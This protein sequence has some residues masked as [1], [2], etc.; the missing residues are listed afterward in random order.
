[1]CLILLGVRAHPR[2]RLVVAAN[3][4][5]FFARPTAAAGWWPDAPEV[6]G[7][8]DLREGGSW[9][10]V[11]RAG[12]LAAVTNLRDPSRL[13]ERAPSRG[14]LVRDFVQGEQPAGRHIAAL[15]A[16]ADAYNGFN[17]LVDDGA[18]TYWYSNAAG[19]PPPVRLADGVYGV[20]NHLLDTPWPKVEQGKAALRA[21]IA[22][23]ADGAL[24]PE[25]LLEVLADRAVA[26]DAA[27]PRTGVGVEME[28]LLSPR[29]IVSPAYGTR[30]STVLL[31]AHDGAATLVERSFAPGGAK[32]GEVRFE[33]RVG[34]G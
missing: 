2:Y 25:P 34:P 13:R 4:D 12:R 27:L 29:F 21:A 20:S 22:G 30:A 17:L 31:V 6:L 23:A 28:R 15:A 24:A 26:D 9:M 5:E 14:A 18:E 33:F 32:H 10:A 3:R 1:M 16:A 11:S 7:G 19:A 8:R